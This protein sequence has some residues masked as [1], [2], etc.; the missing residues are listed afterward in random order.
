ML[1]FTTAFALMVMGQTFLFESTVGIIYS[2]LF[3][4]VCMNIDDEFHKYC[5]KTAFDIYMSRRYKF[6]ALFVAVGAFTSNVIYRRFALD[7]FRIKHQW[8]NTPCI[9]EHGFKYMI[10][11]DYSFFDFDVVF[12]GLGC[13]FGC[14]F[15]TTHI[16][17][18]L[19]Q[20][21]TFEKKFTRTLIGVG[22]VVIFWSILSHI[23]VDSFASD[24]ILRRAI[25]HFLIS[26]FTYGL[27]PCTWGY[28]GLLVNDLESS[29]ASPSFGKSAEKYSGYESA[30]SDSK[31]G[32]KYKLQ[33][34]NLTIMFSH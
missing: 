28:F 16:D 4:I 32:S 21:S 26:Y 17:N 5:E 25:T 12:F 27:Y 33:F 7:T 29:S 10:G 6:Y 19:M 18:Y 1:M 9:Q 24:F 13:I 14:A 31:P 3:A 23:P 34:Y 15:A 11:I 30:Y 22:L 2:T 8:L 20:E